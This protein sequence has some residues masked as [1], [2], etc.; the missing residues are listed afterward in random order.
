MTCEPIQYEWWSDVAAKADEDGVRLDI[1]KLEELMHLMIRDPIGDIRDQFLRSMQQNLRKARKPV[2][3]LNSCV[4]A[5]IAE[6]IKNERQDLVKA[7]SDLVQFL[8][9]IEDINNTGA[10]RG[11]YY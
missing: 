2:R 11:A 4:P 7:L 3:P 10:V 1:P 8:I 5:G 9:K 6:T